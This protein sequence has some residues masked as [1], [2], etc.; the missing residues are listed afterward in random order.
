MTV[1]LLLH[2][3]IET[4]LMSFISLLFAY[5]L[6]LPLGILLNM[7]S[8]KGIRPNQTLNLIIGTIVNILRSIPCLL[9]I[10]ILIPLT[11]IVFGRGSW[12]G[13]WYS[14]IIPLVV[15][16][17]AFVARMVEQSLSE[18]DSSVIEASRSLGAN[19]WQI[20]TKVLLPEAKSSLLSGLAVTTVSIIGYTSFAGYIAAGGL[21]VE[22]FNLGYYGTDQMGMWLC[23]FIVVIIVQIIQEGGLYFAKKIDKR[24]ILK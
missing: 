12:S 14:M 6:G 24:R 19:D 17:F 16:S 23:V 20:I 1:E 11:N 18:I 13:N 22:A 15:A 7:T 10:I 5:L 8:K 4:L 9:L 21:I 2:A 3:T